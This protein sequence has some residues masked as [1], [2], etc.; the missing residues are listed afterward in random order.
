MQLPPGRSKWCTRIFNYA[1]TRRPLQL[2]PKR[3]NLR[4]YAHDQLR[5]EQAKFAIAYG[6]VSMNGWKTN[7]LLISTGLAWAMQGV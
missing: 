4:Y 5:L 1:M 3:S 7:V 2:D 6:V